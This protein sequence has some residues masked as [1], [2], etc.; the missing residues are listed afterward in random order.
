MILKKKFI[1]NRIKLL[2]CDNYN[3]CLRN[4]NNRCK[5]NEKSM[6]FF[7]YIKKKYK[8]IKKDYSFN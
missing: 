7:F 2:K 8:K 6:F 3:E 5:K 1:N 4:K